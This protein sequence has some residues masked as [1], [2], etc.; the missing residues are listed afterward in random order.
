MVEIGI[1][2]R[3]ISGAT[4]FTFMFR[5]TAR[6]LKEILTAGPNRTEGSIR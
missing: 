4:V 5:E 6:F 2:G 3:I 1:A